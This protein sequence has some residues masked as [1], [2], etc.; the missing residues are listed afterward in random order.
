MINVGN[1]RSLIELSGISENPGPQF[2]DLVVEKLAAREKLAV[3]SH[4]FVSLVVM[5]LCHS[6][7]I[8]AGCKLI[9]KDMLC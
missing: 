7:S 6:C 5:I 4:L 9:Y 1:K 2:N 8:A 3:K